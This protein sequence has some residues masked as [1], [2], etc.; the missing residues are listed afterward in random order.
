M[1][2]LKQSQKQTFE[3]NANPLQNPTNICLRRK[4]VGRQTEK[5]KKTLALIHKMRVIRTMIH[6]L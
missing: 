1:G 6:V 3:R 5:K 2:K 4:H